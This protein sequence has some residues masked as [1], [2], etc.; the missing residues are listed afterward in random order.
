MKCNSDQIEKVLKSGINPV[1]MVSGD[2]LLLCEETVALI[3][4]KAQG[5]GFD[6]RQLFVY[7][8]GFDWDALSYEIQNQSLF[9]NQKIIELRLNTN[10]I[11]DRGSSAIR[12]MLAAASP[13]TVLII[14][15]PKLDSAAQRSK[16]VK[17]LIDKAVLVQVWNVDSTQLPAWLEKRSRDKGLLLS[18]ES[19]AL[20]VER[21]EGNLLAASQEIDKL[22]LLNGEGRVDDNLVKQAIADSAKY[23][24]YALVDYCLS[25]QVNKVAHVLEGLKSEGVEAVLILWALSREIR[26]LTQMAHR[27]ENG[28]SIEQVLMEFRVWERRKPLLRSALVRY[29]VPQWF[30][31]LA[32][33]EKI[34]QQV[35]GIDALNVWDSLLRLSLV[36]AGRFLFYPKVRMTGNAHAR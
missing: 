11:G 8:K 33:C 14:V 17:E 29:S 2:E 12:D 10:Q 9:S 15:G 36:L 16:W 24:V 13:E 27:C 23:S 21:V 25:A 28:Q 4:K 3:R 7:E 22:W 32:E 18:K 31:I 26:M 1:Y 5:N 20:L 35:K 30:K 6:E 19:I 34:D